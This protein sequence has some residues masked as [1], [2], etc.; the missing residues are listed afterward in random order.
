MIKKNKNNDN[1]ILILARGGSV[2]I[3]NKNLQKIH[4]VSLLKKKILM[5]KKANIGRIVVSS[6]CHKI[7][8]EASNVKGIETFKRNNKYS[9]S[10]AS[11][12]SAILE[13][14]RA[15]KKKNCLP[16]YITLSPVTN[17]FLDF[18]T[19]NNAYRKIKKS[20]NL[21]SLISITECSEHPYLHVKIEKKLKFNIF[22]L[23]RKT[24]L[25]FERSQDVPKSYIESAS[26]RISKID[27]FLKYLS[28][29]NP[30]FSKPLFDQRSCGFIKIKKIESFDINTLYDLKLAR[31]M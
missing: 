19:L 10:Y 22:K 15:I 3:K 8:K 30:N 14:L 2:R 5:C 23:D 1:L 29:K 17:P 24:G 28:N 16:K 13:Y 6:E 31:I 27:Y 4:G 20:N 11:S 9:T 26:V 7:L 12:I 25:N 21:K 18:K